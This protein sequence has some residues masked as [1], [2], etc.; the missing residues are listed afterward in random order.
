MWKEIKFSID[1]R[2]GDSK[3][4]PKENGDSTADSNALLAAEEEGAKIAFVD[5]GT[6]LLNVYFY[7]FQATPPPTTLMA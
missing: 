1:F 4:V 3:P 6:P 5:N 2:E 7:V